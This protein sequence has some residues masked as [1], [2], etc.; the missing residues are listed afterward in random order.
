MNKLK[1]ISNMFGVPS[2]RHIN[3]IYRQIKDFNLTVSI[4]VTLPP[5]QYTSRIISIYYVFVL[6]NL[7]Y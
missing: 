6:I 2:F 1:L 4:F 5:T 3:V 7:G